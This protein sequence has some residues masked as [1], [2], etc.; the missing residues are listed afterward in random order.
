MSVAWKGEPGQTDRLLTLLKYILL[1]VFFT[2]AVFGALVSLWA[3]AKP[4]WVRRLLRE[5]LLKTMLLLI[6]LGPVMVVFAIL[7]SQ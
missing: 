1:E 2:A 6:A 5:R 3:I 4:Q 7:A